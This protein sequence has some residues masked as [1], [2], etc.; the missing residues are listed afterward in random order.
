LARY[1]TANE[2]DLNRPVSTQVRVHAKAKAKKRA[3]PPPYPQEFFLEDYY[4]ANDVPLYLTH[5][6]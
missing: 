3:P 5:E 6:A 1:F 2:R 4:P